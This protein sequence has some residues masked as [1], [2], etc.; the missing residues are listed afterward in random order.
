VTYDEAKGN[1]G[2]CDSLWT[3][4]ARIRWHP[5]ARAWHEEDENMFM[6]RMMCRTIVLVLS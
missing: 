3:F 1:T 5:S 4:E 2:T 6:T